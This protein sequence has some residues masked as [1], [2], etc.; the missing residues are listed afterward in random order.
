MLRRIAEL[1][2]TVMGNTVRLV[3]QTV[4]EARAMVEA[5][6]PDWVARIQK[7]ET[8]RRF[9]RQHIGIATLLAS[10]AS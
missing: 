1:S 4:E 6:S 8:A 5:M 9:A 7:F 2:Y 10:R 3:P